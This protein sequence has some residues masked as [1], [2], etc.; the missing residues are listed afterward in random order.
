MSPRLKHA[1]REGGEGQ[2]RLWGG[3]GGGVGVG[4]QWVDGARKLVRLSEF[5]N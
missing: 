1:R 4:E 5:Y 2:R 3:V